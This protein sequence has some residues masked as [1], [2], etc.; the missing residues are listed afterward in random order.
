MTLIKIQ[1]NSLIIPVSPSAGGKSSFGRKHFGEQAIISSDHCRMLVGGDETRQ[2]INQQAFELFHNIIDTRMKLGVLTFADATNLEVRA[3]KAL[4]AIAERYKRPIHVLVM[5]APLEILL[6]NNQKRERKVPEYVLERHITRFHGEAD[7]AIQEAEAPN[8]YVT[9]LQFPYN[10]AQIQY[11]PE[12]NIHTVDS[13]SEWWVIGDVHGC[14]EELM[15]LVAMIPE[16]DRLAF[17]GDFIDR[18][19]MPKEV[20]NQVERWIKTGRAVAVLGNHCWKGYRGIVLGRKVTM[21]NGL[22]ETAEKVTAE[23]LAFIGELPFQVHLANPKNP[24]TIVTVTHGAVRYPDIGVDN[25]AVRALNLY[26][27]TDGTTNNVGFPT[28]TYDWVNTWNG[29]WPE[30]ICVFGHT[31]NK[32][33]Q[34]MGADSNCI[35]VDTG[36]AFGGKLSAYN[37][38]T[39]DVLQVNAR[40]V[41]SPKDLK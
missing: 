27:E 2:D 10:T 37:P 9:C 12:L 36:C 32:D 4:Y 16:Q 22:A 24:H 1:P 38:F 6:E 17:V 3:R 5:D 34:V 35:N 40:E 41:Y 31:P 11:T 13:N 19:P 23:D 7:K 28:R 14:Y 21:S 25:K 30:A 26:G 39:G 15:D 8:R 33:I 20:L 18:G 29:K